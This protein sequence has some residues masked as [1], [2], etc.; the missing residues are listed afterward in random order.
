MNSSYICNCGCQVVFTV[1]SNVRGC[2]IKL[3]PESYIIED[4][5]VND[6]WTNHIGHLRTWSELKNKIISKAQYLINHNMDNNN[7]NNNNIPNLWLH[8][9]NQYIRR[10]IFSDLCPQTEL[11]FVYIQ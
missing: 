2:L 1:Q 11:Q 3:T 6:T 8:L 7:N 9:Y 10:N 5:I 4:R